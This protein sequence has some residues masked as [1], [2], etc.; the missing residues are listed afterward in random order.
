MALGIGICGDCGT[1][2]DPSLGKTLF[3]AVKKERKK[4]GLKSVLKVEKRSCL[5]RCDTPCNAELSGKRRPTL[6]LSLI[7]I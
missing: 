1:K 7:H 2:Q 3:R 5:D 4:R 6:Q